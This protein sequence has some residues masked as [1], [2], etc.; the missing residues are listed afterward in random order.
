MPGGGVV[1]VDVLVPVRPR[2]GEVAV[3]VLVDELVVVVVD[4]TDV[5]GVMVDGVEI[6][7]TDVDGI[8][9]DGVVVVLSGVVVWPAVPT[10]AVPLVVVPP[11]V[12]PVVPPVTCADDGDRDKQR[13]RKSKK[14]HETLPD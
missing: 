10:V 11:D 8:V 14:S 13:G 5:D 2:R 6:E 7:G 1:L 9:C 12:P 3:V 4:G